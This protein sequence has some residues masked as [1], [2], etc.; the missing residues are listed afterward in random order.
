VVDGSRGEHA[1]MLTAYYTSTADAYRELWAPVL[2]IPSQSMLGELPLRDARRVLDL[3]TGVG[4][5]LPDLRRA[6]PRSTIVAVDYTIGMLRLASPDVA[7]VAADATRLPFADACFDVA[8]LAF[9]LFHVPEP[10][11]ALREVRRVLAEG[12]MI[13]LTTWSIAGG[14]RAEQVWAA[15]LDAY[16]APPAPPAMTWHE[17][18]DSED[19]LG[20]LLAQSG[21]TDI[22]SRIDPFHHAPDLDQ[23]IAVNA[24]LGRR[25]QAMPVEERERFLARVRKALATLAAEDFVDTDDVIVTTAVAAPV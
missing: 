15:E 11:D 25:F 20:A 4:A 12:G 8:V 10:R 9:M 18:V 24:L 17:L 22:R 23:F 3:G 2:R 5:L 19:K 7:R 16:G 21:F 14:S 1:A 13:G 6:A